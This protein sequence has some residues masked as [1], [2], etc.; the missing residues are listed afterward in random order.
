MRLRAQWAVLGASICMFETYTDFGGL[1]IR[2][3]LEFVDGSLPSVTS[4]GDTDLPDLTSLM[5]G[6]HDHRF[7]LPHGSGRHYT[8]LRS[9][10]P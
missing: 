8:R 7:V 4:S 3:A 5:A 6:V 2:R 10:S 9:S 1:S